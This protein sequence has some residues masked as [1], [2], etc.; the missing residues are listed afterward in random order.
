M[1]PIIA[2]LVVLALLAAALLAPQAA[3]QAQKTPG[4]APAG[5]AEASSEGVGGTGLQQ[6]F[7]ASGEAC[8]KAAAERRRKLG[9][10]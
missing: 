8:H 3:A 6:Y 7:P 5:E 9:F 10:A 1:R 2:S 4:A